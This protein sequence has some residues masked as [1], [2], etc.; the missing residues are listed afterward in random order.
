MRQGNEWRLVV[1]MWSNN[2][3]T[4]PATISRHYPDTAL[5]QTLEGAIRPNNF[6]IPLNT[7]YNPSRH[8]CKSSALR[9]IK[10]LEIQ[11]KVTEYHIV[12]IQSSVL[13]LSSLIRYQETLLG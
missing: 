9:L 12:E 8:Q 6:T 2:G 11:I 4:P 1:I 10:T 3:A 7:Y 13:H 5:L